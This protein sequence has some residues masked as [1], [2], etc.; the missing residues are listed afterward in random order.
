MM[1]QVGFLVES[2][3]LTHG[4]CSVSNKELLRAWPIP[5]ACIA[6]VEDGGLRVGTME[7]FVPFR[8]R[9][10]E[11]IRVNCQTLD[12]A[13]R[14]K[15]RGALTASGTMAAATRMNVSLAVT[16][17]MGGI[18]DIPGER[19]CPD[20]P[21]VRDIPVAL[22]AAAPKDVVDAAATIGWFRR[23]NVPVYGRYDPFVSGFMTVGERLPLD[24]VFSGGCPRPPALL[25]NPIAEEERLTEPGLVERAR[26]AGRAALTEGRE[27]HPAANGE[28]DRLSG[29]RSSRLQL[30]QLAENALWAGEL[31]RAARK[32]K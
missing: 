25:L 22:I 26:A 20:L 7:E 10:E 14:E 11:A 3:L 16:C 9:A 30:R 27:Y 29:G 8:A 12:G 28:F 6:W 23:E 24:G 2:A 32:G 5:Q 31:L 4:L 18:C 21:A 13:L 15:R 1:D 17:G 19:L